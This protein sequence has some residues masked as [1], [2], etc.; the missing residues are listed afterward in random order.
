[1]QT[2]P[3]SGARHRL[4][5]KLAREVLR[6]ETRTIELARREARR[7][8]AVPPAMALQSIARHADE[9]APRLYDVLEPLGLVPGSVPGSGALIALRWDGIRRRVLEHRDPQRAAR[10]YQRV[11]A[12]LRHTIEVV[13]V[14]REAAR[15]EELFALI[16]WSDDWLAARRPRVAEAEVQVAWFARRHRSSRIARGT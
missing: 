3:I 10:E 15:L 1:M 6:G 7:L 4:L 2:L 11:V 13:R 14:L 12:E 8:G 5:D 9:L 16:R